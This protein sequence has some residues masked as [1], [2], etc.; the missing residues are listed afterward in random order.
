LRHPV[1]SHQVGR[2]IPAPSRNMGPSAG[3]PSRR[4]RPRDPQSNDGLAAT[5]A[6]LWPGVAITAT[7]RRTNSA[8]NAGIRSYWP[9]KPVVFDRC[10][11]VVPVAGFAKPLPERS[12]VCVGRRGSNEPDHRRCCILPGRRDRPHRRTK[13]RDELPP[14]HWIT[15]SAVAN[16]VSGIERP[17]ALAVLRLMTISNLV[18]CC[19][20][21]RRASRRAVS[22]RHTR[23]DRPAV[24]ALCASCLATVQNSFKSSATRTGPEK[25]FCTSAT[26]DA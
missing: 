18:G 2:S 5:A 9:S 25:C 14:S 1:D 20:A 26:H 15:S 19:R 23:L 4:L 21:D 12:H 22:D 6:S 24:V 17:S 8:T 10:V 13:S 3:R 7:R 16:S 11:P